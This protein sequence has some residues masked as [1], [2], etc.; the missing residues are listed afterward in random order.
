MLHPPP[1]FSLLPFAVFVCKATT[2]LAAM[3]YS[4]TAIRLKT[5]SRPLS[6]AKEYFHLLELLELTL[7][8]FHCAIS[9][10]VGLNGNSQLCCRIYDRDNSRQQI[11]LQDTKWPET[12]SS[13]PGPH[14]HFILYTTPTRLQLCIYNGQM[15][16]YIT[17][18][19]QMIWGITLFFRGSFAVE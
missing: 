3:N 15:C 19:E 14:R 2:P 9:L 13:L 18:A 6:S 11:T 7:P 16:P 12:A 5:L 4:V 8:S 17:V 1:T 10:S